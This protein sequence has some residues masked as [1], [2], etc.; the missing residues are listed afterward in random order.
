MQ[1]PIEPS[2]TD[3]VETPRA[4]T[5]EEGRAMFFEHISGI[6]SYWRD[7]DLPPGWNAKGQSETEYRMEGFLFSLFVLFD[8]GSGFMPGFNIFPAPHEDDEEYRR[9]QGEN[10]WSPTE[11][12]NDNVSMHDSFN[13]QELRK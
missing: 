5:A 9:S 11:P 3:A 7:I 8:G 1:H 12:I 10:W 4:Y 13:W 2:M 6:Y